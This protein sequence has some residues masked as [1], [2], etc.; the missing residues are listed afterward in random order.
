VRRVLL[1][2]IAAL[3]VF[4]TTPAK[5]TAPAGKTV[6]ADD[7]FIESTIKGKLA[8]SKIGADKFKF[9]VQGGVVYWEGTTDVPQHKGAA[10]RMAKTAGAVRVVN[11]IQVSEA[12]KAKARS[13]FEKSHRSEPRSEP[14]NAVVKH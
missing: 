9:R 6:A 1:L 12:G 11:N 8:K 7:A 10:T 3:T 4:G 13:Q 14:R 2:L 5:T